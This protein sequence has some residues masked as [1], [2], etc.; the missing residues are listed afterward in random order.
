MVVEI[1]RMCGGLGSS[2]DQEV[3]HNNREHKVAPQA[4]LEHVLETKRVFHEEEEEGCV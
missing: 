3:S 2:G 1:G 4:K